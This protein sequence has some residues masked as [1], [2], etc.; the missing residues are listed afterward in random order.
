MNS[1]GDHLEHTGFT[2]FDYYH[3]FKRKIARL[4]NKQ[5]GLKKFAL[6]ENCTFTV[7]R[8]NRTVCMLD[9]TCIY[10]I[11]TSVGLARAQV[12]PNNLYTMSF[13]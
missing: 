7:R 2:Y 11:S 3:H 4:R 8:S 9:H 13:M 6:K 10:T 1:T 5:F 12:R